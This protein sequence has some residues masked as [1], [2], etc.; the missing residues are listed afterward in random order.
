L[1]S[2]NSISKIKQVLA[3]QGL[4]AAIKNVITVSG[5][6]I[7]EC[8]KI[9]TDVQPYFLKVNEVKR[10]PNMF[11]IESDSLLILKETNTIKTPNVIAQFK[12]QYHQYL[13]LKWIE[14]S[15]PKNTFWQHFAVD[16]AQLHQQSSYQFGLEFDNYIG[17]LKQQNTFTNNWTDFYI[18]QRIQP[19]VELAYN[20]QKIS[21]K[22]LSQFYQFYKTLAVIFPDEKPILIH[23]DLWDGNFLCDQ[24]QKAV[25]IDPAIY[26]ANREMEIASTQLFGGFHP[27]FYNVYNEI[28]PLEKQFDKRVPVYN[29][30][31]LLVHLNLFGGHYFHQVMKVVNSY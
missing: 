18:E 5:G 24:N 4:S 3:G 13:L 16:L 6:C 25:I 22:N 30:Y 10:Y 14:S 15:K 17:S 26:Y 28:Y 1:L 29:L 23:G 27:T 7:N 21:K 8:Y 12:D 31:S 20:N 11:K 19:Q 9:E 2:N